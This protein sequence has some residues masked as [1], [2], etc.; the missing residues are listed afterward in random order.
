MVLAPQHHTCNVTRSAQE[1]LRPTAT[2]MT[3]VSGTWVRMAVSPMHQ[4]VASVRTTHVRFPRAESEA[5]EPKVLGRKVFD[6][7]IVLSPSWPLLLRPVQSTA[8]FCTR[9]VCASP[10]DIAEI[11][12]CCAGSAA[13]TMRVLTMQAQSVRKRIDNRSFMMS[14]HSVVKTG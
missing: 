1:C 4:S 10:A 13:S 9:H 11:T 12:P 6:S 3:P 8:A 5:T 14:T 7:I 2:L